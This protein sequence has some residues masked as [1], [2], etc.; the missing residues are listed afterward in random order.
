MSVLSICQEFREAERTPPINVCGFVDMKLKKNQ[1]PSCEWDVKGRSEV[2]L[3]VPAA[4][5]V[6][7]WSELQ[8]I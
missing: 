2:C 3:P 7:P 8:L 4:P 1:A 5:P 6:Q